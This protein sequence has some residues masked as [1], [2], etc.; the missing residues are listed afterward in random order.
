MTSRGRS[1]TYHLRMPGFGLQ[2]GAAGSRFKSALIGFANESAFHVNMKR[3][4]AWSKKGSPAVNTVPKTRAQ[5]TTILGAISASAKSRSL[6]LSLQRSKEFWIS[7]QAHQFSWSPMRNAS[8]WSWKVFHSHE[9][10]DRAYHSIESSRATPNIIHHYGEVR[11]DQ[12]QA[13]LL[14]SARAVTSTGDRWAAP[15][16]RLEQESTKKRLR[17]SDV[18]QL[19]SDEEKLMAIIGYYGENNVLGLRSNGVVPKRFASVLADMTRMLSFPLVLKATSKEV[20]ILSQ[21]SMTKRLGGI[22][23]MISSMQL[24]DSNDN[25]LYIHHLGG[26]RAK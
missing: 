16:D 4:M 11:D 21:I 22:S 18:K 24:Q 17:A 25:L 13:N 5:T 19:S 9:P 3:S 2:I 10:S 12:G 1:A 26:E 20:A 15:D 14:P 7:S 8:L 23:Q 6:H